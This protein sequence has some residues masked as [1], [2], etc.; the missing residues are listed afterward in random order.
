MNEGSPFLSAAVAAAIA[1]GIGWLV[2]WLRA[3]DLTE[4]LSAKDAELKKATELANES[5]NAANRAANARVD[6]ALKQLDAERERLKGEEYRIR[7]HYEGESKRFRTEME[8]AL[9]TAK[10]EAQSLQRFAALRGAEA[11]MSKVLAAALSEA[12]ALKTEATKL[13]ESAQLAG[14]EERSAASKKAADIRAQADKLLEHATRKA[15]EIVEK[16]DADAKK[17][18]GDAYTALREREHLDQSIRAIRNLVEG[19][20]DKYVVPTRSIIDD[21]AAGYGHTDAGKRLELARM[22]SSKMVTEGQAADCDYVET[23]RRETAVRFVVDA[24]NGRVD[25]LLTEAESENI[26]TLE[27]RIR[28]AFQIVNLNGEAFRNARILPAYLDA[29]LDEL[30]WAVA[31]YELR[32]REREEQRRIKEQI[33]EEER[34]RKEYERAIREAQ[35]EEEKIQRAIAK[36]RADAEQASAQDRAKFEQELAAL[37]E[38]LAAAEAKNQR[39]LSMAQQTR[40]GNVYII[41]NVGSF[42]DEVFKIGMTRRLEPMDRI[43]ELSDASVPFDFDVHALIACDDAPA[44]EGALHE[45]FADHRVNLVNERKE[46]FRVPLQQ[47]REIVAARGIEAQFTMLAEAHEFRESQKVREMSPAERQR[48][49]DDLAADAALVSGGRA[50]AMNREEVSTDR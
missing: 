13:L 8:I 17:I 35:E 33:R 38:K 34:A 6:E 1:M 28:D 22:R 46:F 9:Q 44:L 47:I 42:G 45:A 10:L 43:W 19:Y 39:A 2:M 27:Q 49:L 12:E 18:A 7:T 4:K 48:Y 31:T 37:N 11:E 14:K 41:S 36:A 5:V 30:R 29:R 32:Q 24:F 25:A 40:K 23:N 26:G 3:R 16:A 15:A 50:G 21:L 20:G